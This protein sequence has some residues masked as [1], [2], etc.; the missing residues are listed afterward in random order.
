MQIFQ[1]ITPA[2]INFYISNT[3]VLVLKLEDKWSTCLEEESLMEASLCY[4]FQLTVSHHHA[5]SKFIS[6]IIV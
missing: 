1:N 3:T 6:S 2:Y 4:L 5:K